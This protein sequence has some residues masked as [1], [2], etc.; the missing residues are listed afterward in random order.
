MQTR[1]DIAILYLCICFWAD[2]VLSFIIVINRGF[3][4]P[5]KFDTSI[6]KLI[7]MT[8]MHRMRSRITIVAAEA[9]DSSQGK[10]CV[11]LISITWFRALS[12]KYWIPAGHRPQM[13]SDDYRYG[14][15]PDW[16]CSRGTVTRSIK[17]A[18]IWWVLAGKV[19]ARAFK[20]GQ[21]KFFQVGWPDPANRKRPNNP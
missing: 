6:S 7:R 16:P 11:W 1:K 5:D 17:S 19:T 3:I 12:I 21:I 10:A 18:G 4:E 8:S 13:A 14:F 15:L 2:F 20:R 9:R